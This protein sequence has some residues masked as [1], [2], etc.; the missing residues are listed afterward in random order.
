L[1]KALFNGLMVPNVGYV[2]R[3]KRSKEKHEGSHLSSKN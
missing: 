3:E 2:A 1:L